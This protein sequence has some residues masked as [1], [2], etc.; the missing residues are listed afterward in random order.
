MCG[1]YRDASPA[2]R[3]SAQYRQNRVANKDAHSALDT[4]YAQVRDLL[5]PHNPRDAGAN[6]LYSAPVAASDEQHLADTPDA[7][8]D[9][10]H[11]AASKES[12]PAVYYRHSQL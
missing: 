2:T 5:A 9:G 12:I 4:Q 6:P 3:H 8:R 10:V 7:Q 1:F 11:P